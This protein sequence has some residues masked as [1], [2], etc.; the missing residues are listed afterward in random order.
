[1][2]RIDQTNEGIGV[3][4]VQSLKQF[5]RVAT[6][7]VPGK[8][9]YKKLAYYLAGVA[10]TPMSGFKETHPGGFLIEKQNVFLTKA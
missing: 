9:R 10:G 2:T 8:S 5:E 7:E 1:M 6:P 4:F 3:Q